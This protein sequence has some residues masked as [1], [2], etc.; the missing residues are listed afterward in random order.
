MLVVFGVAVAVGAA[1][2]EDPSPIAAAFQSFA[3]GSTVGLALRNA[4][5][6]VPV[7]VL[8]IAVLLAAFI[9]ALDGRLQ[10]RGQRRTALVVA[11]V[12]CA[13]CLANAPGVWGGSYYSNY[14][15]W[16]GVPNYWHQAVST[17]DAQPHD[18]RVLTLPGSSFAAYRWGDVLDPIEPTL[19]KRPY[20]T[21]Q[22]TPV[23]SEA[24][25]ALLQAVDGRLQSNLL[26]P[27]ALA[28]LAR[29]MGVGDVLLNM[30]LETDRYGLIPP[31]SLWNSFTRRTPAGLGTPQTFGPKVRTLADRLSDVARPPTKPPPA[32]RGDR[33]RR[34]AADRAHRFRRRS[35]RDRR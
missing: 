26:D 3:G 7:I 19:T 5:R 35:A 28:P 25:A 2:Y 10:E 17:V 12:V 16:T 34:P 6:A 33:R 4:D 30:D 18:T 11:G 21:R 22:Q 20:I 15:E 29:L 8:G 27:N 13:L 31:G 14:L 23:G 1:P 9:S 32:G 24:T